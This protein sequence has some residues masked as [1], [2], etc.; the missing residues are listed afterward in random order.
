MQLTTAL[1]EFIHQRGGQTLDKEV[2]TFIRNGFIDTLAVMYAGRNEDA[3]RI[4]L[5]WLGQQPQAQEARVYGQDTSLSARNAAYV[6]GVAAH[7]LDFDDVGLQGHPSAVLAPAILAEGERLGCSGAQMM[8]AYAIGYEVW[9]ELIARDSDV[10]HLKGWHP[11]SVFGTV[12]A[13]AAMAALRQSPVEVIRHA[14]GIAASMASGLT[15]NFGSMTKPFHAGMAAAH[16]IDALN[17]AELGLTSSPDVLE[18]PRGFLFAISPQ[19][20]V[21]LSAPGADFLQP[22]RMLSLGLI[23]KKYPMCFATHRVIDA[24]IDLHQAHGV[25]TQD[26]ERID[27]YVG[28]AQAAM[29]RNSHPQNGLQAKFSLQFAIAAP[30]VAGRCGL[31]EL[32][33]SFVLRPEVQAV[34]DQV[35]IHTLDTVHPA[36]PTLARSDRIVLTLHSGQ[37]LDSGEVLDARGGLGNP[38]TEQDIRAKFLDCTRELPELQRQ[39]LFERLLAF[40]TLDSLQ[41]VSF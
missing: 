6:N 26:I 30:L 22:P 39:V 33:D 16:A 14:L 7:A 29:L 18:H 12:A 28:K 32:E 34:F 8:S 10:H 24:V 15:A 21:D 40:E 20:K 35:H 1:A 27:V 23:V 31:L 9:A 41:E 37:Q 4:T 13:A 36:E 38:L 5:R 17:L 25:T 2:R 19:G 11:T 3:V